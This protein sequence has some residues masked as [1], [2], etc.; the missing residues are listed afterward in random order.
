MQCIL[1]N[2]LV[3]YFYIHLG[4]IDRQYFFGDDTNWSNIKE[5]IHKFSVETIWAPEQG[6]MFFS[7]LNFTSVF[8][9]NSHLMSMN[10][11]WNPVLRWHESVYFYQKIMCL[12]NTWTNISVCAVQWTFTTIV[13][14]YPNI[15]Q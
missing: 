2:G 14:Y 4:D 3:K 15:H 7:S 13:I 5:V 6:Y 8:F 9:S 11:K 1:L 10:K 12:P